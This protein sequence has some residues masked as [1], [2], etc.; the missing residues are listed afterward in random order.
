LYQLI[1][2]KF[3]MNGV[4]LEGYPNCVWYFFMSYNQNKPLGTGVLKFSKNLG[5]ISKFWVPEG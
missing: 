1:A 4:S 2:I 3:L 5:P